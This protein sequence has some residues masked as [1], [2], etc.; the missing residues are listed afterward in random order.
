MHRLISDFAF[1]YPILEKKD[2]HL[3]G[4]KIISCQKII[5]FIFHSVHSA[6][7]ICCFASY[8]ETKTML[9]HITISELNFQTQYITCHVP[10]LN[11]N[12]SDGIIISPLL[13]L[14][15]INIFR[16]SI[17]YVYLVGLVISRGGVFYQLLT[18]RCFKIPSPSSGSRI[19]VE[20]CTPGFGIFFHFRGLLGL[21]CKKFR[22]VGNV[23]NLKH[24]TLCIIW[25]ISTVS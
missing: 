24:M 10:Y 25:S 14:N 18:R 2:L 1:F 8:K 6:N 20:K 5:S 15:F 3:R 17:F 11:Q 21:V 16:L 9:V 4:E 7:D 13:D 23:A 12:C 19:F 22:H